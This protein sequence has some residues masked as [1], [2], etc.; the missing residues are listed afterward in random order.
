[1][2]SI[3]FFLAV[4]S[5]LSAGLVNAIS[6]IV[7][8]EA[9][10]LYD[11][12]KK[13]LEFKID[14]KDALKLLIRGILEKQE[15]QKLRIKISQDEVDEEILRLAKLN[16]LSVEEF[17]NGIVISK[18]FTKEVFQ[19]TI[20][21]DILKR[22]LYDNISY[23]KIQYPSEKEL[24]LYYQNN[25]EKYSFYDN[26]S[27]TQYQSVSKE[28]LFNLIKN[29][30]AK[31]DSIKIK[32]LDVDTKLINPNFRN[33]LSFTKEGSFTKI[34]PAQNSFVVFFINKKTNKSSPKISEIKDLILNDFISFKKEVVLSEYFDILK[35]KARVTIL[36]LPN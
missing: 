15:A 7:N 17:Y 36:R 14:K 19:K 18:G 13:S 9:I 11:I 27:L 2:K 1:M 23:S 26:V 21:E 16:Q 22:K 6:V 30:L 3:I 33:I 31:F 24:N 32:K 10:S 34:M 8:G 25:K 35:D 4:S 29:P 5:F 12:D 28:D 20:K